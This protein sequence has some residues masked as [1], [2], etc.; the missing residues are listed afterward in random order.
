MGYFSTAD[1]CQFLPLHGFSINF[2]LDNGFEFVNI[3]LIS[4]CDISRLTSKREERV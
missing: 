4:L 2:E 3:L 1:R